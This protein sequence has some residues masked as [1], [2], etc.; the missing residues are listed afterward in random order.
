MRTTPRLFAAALAATAL[1]V[2]LATNASAGPQ[3]VPGT[4]G[5]AT[6]TGVSEPAR[7][8]FYEPP[9]SL[10]TAGTVIRSQD[11][12]LLLDPFKLSSSVVTST[13]I[14]Y[15]STDRLDRRIAV[16][17][18]V[19]VPKKAWNGKGQRPVITYAAGT[20][21]MG[22]KCAPSKQMETLVEYEGPGMAT[23]IAS[24]Y[25]VVITDYQGLGTPG[26][27]TYVSREVTGRNV[28]DAARAAKALP[29]SGLANAPVGITGYSQGGNGAAAAVE[30][31]GTYAPDLDVK[32]A[33]VGAVPADLTAVAKNLDGGLYFN[34]LLYAVIGQTAGHNVD[35][36]PFLNARGAE[37]VKK[38]ENEC[39]FSLLSNSF[40]KSKDITVDGRT[41]SA[42][43]AEEP[44]KSVLADNKIG[45]R[46]PAA[47]TLVTH[48]LTDDVI[49]YSVGRTMAKDWC[50]KGG[51][52][53]FS[54]SLTPLHLGGA[55]PHYAKSLIY[56][57]DTF[58]SGRTP[59]TNCWA[60]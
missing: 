44:L 56:F 22:D 58:K 47:P 23:L 52:V 13:R 34:F 11:A 18:T 26:S 50:K 42:H 37:A 36:L 4:A 28:L 6:L 40:T 31:A 59:S 8:A 19:F 48:S 16:T 60:L 12:P 33:A 49:P 41:I 51:R 7:D 21:G 20:Q 45:N 32:A 35:P 5:A 38:I 27:H 55:L 24:G 43:L 29:G 3:D 39:V 17:G 1:T 14:M 53:Q 57:N 15:A 9:A 54:S 30:L 46:K 25:A 2:P 10:P